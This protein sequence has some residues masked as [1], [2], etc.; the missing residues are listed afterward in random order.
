MSPSSIRRSCA[1]RSCGIARDD[2]MTVVAPIR[3]LVVDDSSFMRKALSAMLDEDPRVAVIATARNGEEAIEKIS[4]L[5]PD[6]VTLDVEMPGMNGLDAL[7]WI[8]DL[9]PVPVLMV[10]SLTEEGARETL[11]ALEF[12]AVDYVPKQLDGVATNITGIQHDLIEK[13]VAAAGLV[14]R[15]HRR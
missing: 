2:A 11:Q 7:R 10:S 14:G 3:V 8:M 12:G 6:V 5:N 9:H 1:K 13:V 15:V 4:E